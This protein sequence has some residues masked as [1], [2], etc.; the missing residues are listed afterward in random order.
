MTS[1]DECPYCKAGHIIVD[2]ERGEE[3][4]DSCGRVQ[5]AQHIRSEPQFA[6]GKQIRSTIRRR[7]ANVQ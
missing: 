2:E 6:S 5:S 7:M 3:I 4:C 1:K